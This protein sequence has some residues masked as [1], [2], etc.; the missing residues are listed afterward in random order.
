LIFPVALYGLLLF[1]AISNVLLMRRPKGE[2]T[3]DFEVLIPARNEAGNLPHLLP[4]LVRAGLSA[5]V[6]DDGSE[7]G[8][9][10]VARSLGARVERCGDRLEPGWTGK[11]RACH[12]LSGLAVRS[13]A[14]FLDADTRPGDDFA[15]GMARMLHSLP[16][17]VQVLSGFPRMLPGAGLE[18]AYL[19]WVPWIL[20]ATNPFGLVART[21]RGHNGFT[22][23]QVTAWRRSALEA[24]DPYSEVRGEILEDVKIGRLLA[25]RRVRVEVADLSS[26]LSVRMYPTL[27]EAIDG[28]SKNSADIAGPG[29]GSVGFALLM[30]TMGW[31]WLF[32]GEL[33][34][35]ALGLFLASKVVTD[36]IVRLPWWT[37]PLMPLTLTA[38]AATVLRSAHL[39]R[40]G[41]IVWKGR[42]YG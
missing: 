36:R 37:V 24:I 8:T 40:R 28:M 7:D 29:A 17:D 20:L 4:P 16:P 25:R 27:R 30:L 3:A 23:G 35:L 14:V 19:G 1:V 34:W 41:A 9:G 12:R 6:L 10:E 38:A 33:W 32:A 31:A 18:P 15:E 26:I 22:N 2:A 39:K 42:T 21:G 11:N 5:T 13:W